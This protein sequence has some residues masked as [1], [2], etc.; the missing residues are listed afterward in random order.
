MPATQPDSRKSDLA[1]I[2]LAKKD[3]N[4]DEDLYRSILKSVCNVESAKELDE[5]NR[6]KLLA[7]FR[8]KGWG[9]PQARGGKKRFPG[10]PSQIDDPAKGPMLKK[11][12]AMLTEARRPWAYVDALAKQMFC[13]D[14]IGWCDTDQLHKI[15]QALVID[16]R[17]H[18][19]PTA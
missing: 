10:T 1:K 3:L 17:R 15:V 9:R 13:I 7:Y 18:G 6:R 8:G 4:L 2:H 12:S 5:P 19:R 14:K 16:A 11:I